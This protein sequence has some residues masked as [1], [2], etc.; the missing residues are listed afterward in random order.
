MVAH[1]ALLAHI[2]GSVNE[3]FSTRGR[4]STR[5]RAWELRCQTATAR[6]LQV[7]GVG[8][9]QKGGTE[10][11]AVRPPLARGRFSTPATS[12]IRA[13]S[14]AKESRGRIFKWLNPNHLHHHFRCRL[15]H[16]F[17]AQLRK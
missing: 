11:N 17:G 15:I 6:N 3:P 7:I 8:S 16:P 12:R 13:N 1:G 4:G 9:Q 10:E 5:D 14:F 2:E